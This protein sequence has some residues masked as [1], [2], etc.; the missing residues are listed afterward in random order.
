MFIH[1]V[2]IAII[3]GYLLKGR[4]MN[5]E[6]IDIKAIW[7]V[8]IS[9]FL[10]FSIVMLIQ[11][12]ILEKGILTYIL[13]FGMYAILVAFIYINRNNKLIVLMGIGFLLNCI[14]IF[15]NGGAMPVG[16]QAIR[17]SG[18]SI[19]INREGLYT[20]I[21]DETKFWLLGDI[22][23]FIG[24]RRYVISIGDVIAAIGMMLIIITGMRKQS[25]KSS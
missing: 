11:K 19:N 16:E 9:F 6:Q 8:I 10:E 17:I 24:L 20:I 18:I 1:A 15:L 12:G 25:T 22:I 5:I 13:D 21:N 7:L 4:L 3:I 14:P 2:V 23:P